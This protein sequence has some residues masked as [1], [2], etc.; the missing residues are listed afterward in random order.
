MRE[1][2]VTKQVVELRSELQRVDPEN[3]TEYNRVFVTA[4]TVGSKAPPVS[5]ARANARSRL[6]HVAG[7][8]ENG[9]PVFAREISEAGRQFESRASTSSTARNAAAT[10]ASVA[11]PS[12][13]RAPIS[14]IVPI[15]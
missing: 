4:P 15:A 10:P 1:R 2:L 14:R 6:P 13:P 12:A 11:L 7:D 8:R 3:L 9:L 5:R